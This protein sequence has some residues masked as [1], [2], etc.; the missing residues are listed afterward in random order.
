MSS[1]NKMLL[2]FCKSDTSSIRPLITLYLI[3][4]DK[5]GTLFDKYNQ[6]SILQETK[7]M[8]SYLDYLLPGFF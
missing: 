2:S 6:N 8:P 1:N 3:S 4:D 5:A 7:K